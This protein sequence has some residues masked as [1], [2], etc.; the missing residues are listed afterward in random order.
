MT[1]EN[2]WAA[3]IDQRIEERVTAERAAMTKA[4]VE[5]FDALDLPG[6]C[7]QIAE[8]RERGEKQ[9]ADQLRELHTSVVKM[10]ASF[11]KLAAAEQTHKAI[12]DLPPLPLRRGDVN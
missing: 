3:Y 5:A 2:D 10:E 4:V 9:M 6:L 11:S 1:D 12:L 7:E 8:A